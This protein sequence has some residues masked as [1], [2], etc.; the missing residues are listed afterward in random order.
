MASPREFAHEDL[1]DLSGQVA[2]VTGG[3]RG[4]GRS[5]V[6]GLARAGA[7]V[8]IASR[9]L[10]NCRRAAA[11]VEA[12]TGRRALAVGFHVG[13]WDDSARL[14]DAVDQEFG[15]IDILVNNAGMSPTYP[16]LREVTEELFDKTIGVNLKGPFRLSVLAAERMASNDGGS[17]VNISSIGSMGGGGARPETAPRDGAGQGGALPYACAKAGLNVLTVGLAQAYAPKVRVNAVLAGSFWTDAS[18]HWADGL[19]DPQTIPLGR[20]AD[21]GEMV[22]TVLY[23]ASNA[24]SFTTGAMLRVDGGVSSRV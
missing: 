20:V 16:S 12:E 1:F 2:V 23:L 22:G 8:V 18:K 14:L 11:E 21:P 15:A 19:V 9:K 6:S 24:S 7:D 10:D 3:S 13:H 5:L 17:I 4:L